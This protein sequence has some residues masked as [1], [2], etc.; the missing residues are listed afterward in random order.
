[1]TSQI[2]RDHQKNLSDEVRD[3][4]S[5]GNQFIAGEKDVK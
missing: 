5:C 2:K 4:S 3:F 1:M